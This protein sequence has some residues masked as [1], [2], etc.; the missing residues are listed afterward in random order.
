MYLVNGGT[1]LALI[2][3]GAGVEL[4]RIV[5]NIHADG[6]DPEKLK[7]VLLTHAHSDHAGGCKF[8]K[9]RYG[10][11][12]FGS[13][14]TAKFV[15]RGDEQGIS[16]TLAKAGGFYP[17]DY[18]FPACPVDGELREGDLFRVGECQLRAI[19]TS[20]H[21]CGML[22]FLMTG[23]GRADLFSGDTIFH[24]GK[25]LMTNV[26][27]CNFQQ[28][29]KASKS[30]ASFPSTLFCRAISRWLSVGASRTFKKLSI[31]WPGWFCPPTSSNPEWPGNEAMNLKS[32]LD[33]EALIA[34]LADLVAINSVNPQY[35]GGPGEGAL[36][37]YVADYFRKN[38]IPFELQRVLEGRSN[39]IARLEGKPGGR[40]LVLEAH[41]D[42]ASELGMRRDPF[43]PQREGNRLYGRGSCDTKAGLAAMMHALKI[44]READVRPEASVILVA[45]VDEEYAFQGVAKFLEKGIHADGAIVAE[46]TGLETVVASK[47]VLRWRLKTRGRTAHSAK[48]HLGI[49]AVNKMAKVLTAMDERFPAVFEKRHH[50][51]L[52][53]PTLNVG[54]IRGGVQVNQ[55]PDSCTIEIDRRLLPG[56]TKESVWKEFEACSPACARTTQSWKWKWNLPCSRTILLRREL[57]RESCKIV[58]KISQELIGHSEIV[59][60]PYGSDASKL[61]RAGIPSIILGPGSI[62]QAHAADEYVELDQVALAAETLCTHHFGI[63]NFAAACPKENVSEST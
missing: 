1:E 25:I 51:L 37:E 30:W 46:P 27:D 6:L 18:H 34:T 61:A 4:E 29:V 40:T 9:E 54:I 48:P 3:A 50:P 52:G 28:Y 5:S 10:A 20:G 21:C 41:M 42:T 36:A 38:S 63:L 45:A 26:Y 19:E 13:P 44:L 7:Y 24:G 23:E 2:D 57:P 11:Q 22:S 31:V 62:D 59:G 43:R 49:N 58:S 32:T 56:E 15:S 12:V 47:G 14:E 33:P 39:V 16:L 8:W 55:V 35:P 53:S 60:V 17:A